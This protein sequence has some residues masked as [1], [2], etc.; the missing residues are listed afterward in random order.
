MTLEGEIGEIQLLERLVELWREGFTGAIRF[1]SDGIIKIIYFKGGDVLSAS[2]NDRADSI[3]EILMRAN[4]VTREHVKQALAKRK[5][6][7][8]LGD[9]LLNLGFITRK[10]LTWARRVQVVGVIRSIAAWKDGSFTIVADYL[11]KR[12]EGT[13][14]PL[15][16]IL[17][18]LIVTEQD[19]T[20]FERALDGGSATFMRTPEFHEV[21]RRLGLNEDAD[22]ITNEIDGQKSA[23]EVALASG[24][25]TFN[26]YKLL[27]AMELLGI[28][29]RND[30]PEV[31][32][33]LSSQSVVV[34]VDDD[35]SF[36]TAGVADAADM[37]ATPAGQP[38]PPSFEIDEA[39][40]TMEIPA[41]TPIDDYPPPPSTPPA[42]VW[43]EPDET[44]AS[45]PEPEP[46]AAAPA[47]TM[48]AWDKPLRP[49]AVP[50]PVPVEPPADATE[51]QWGFDEAQI[52]TAR[53]A[54]EPAIGATTLGPSGDDDAFARP[55]KKRSYG[56]LVALLLLA[57]VG[58]AAYFGFRWW[59]DDQATKAAALQPP[60]EPVTSAPAPVQTA[61]VAPVVATD[62]GT[63]APAATTDP[64]ATATQSTTTT[65]TA[66]PAP[67]A[68]TTVAPTPTPAPRA[69]PTPA[70][71]AT[72]TSSALP[73]VTP[74]GD[75][76]SRQRYDAMARDFAASPSGNFTVQF[77][78]FCQPRSV[79]NALRAGGDNVWFVRH[80]NSCYRVFW[81][82]YETRA[83]AQQA[84][85]GLPA[86][87]R[88][89]ATAV[90][91][92][93][94]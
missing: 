68:T 92:V 29:R 94:R 12:E 14:F 93:P 85:A 47:S 20:R 70:P 63:T 78:I 91:R 10:E 25:D 41:M 28:L 15:P 89:P 75:A 59:Q 86:S 6:S 39:A 76:A 56:L 52:E 2:T 30:K 21:Y 34:P 72:S 8:T 87:L 53:R 71:A 11:P 19:R 82:H 79:T 24:K 57:I 61:S 88:D 58:G 44:L 69:A 90:V 17:V 36:E 50:M 5:E 60:P 37:W 48:P 35:F 81:G 80:G 26:V 1:E 27:H 54:S 9:A 66:P 84:L 46:V 16:Q 62:T 55:R 77:A 67:P 51:E 74:A 38:D 23:V 65:A 31:T 40:P 49:A 32:P 64:A 83:E 3:D 42:S 33:E 18:E 45:A 13:L 43:D 4:K 22:A 7:E 73:V